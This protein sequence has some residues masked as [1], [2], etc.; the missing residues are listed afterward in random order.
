MI[1][2]LISDRLGVPDHLLRHGDGPTDGGKCL[3]VIF[4]EDD[5]ATVQLSEPVCFSHSF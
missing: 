1:S 4:N 5:R 2:R 3:E